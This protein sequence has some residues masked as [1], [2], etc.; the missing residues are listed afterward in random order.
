MSDVDGKGSRLDLREEPDGILCVALHGDMSEETM[1]AMMAALRR[2]AESSREVLVLGDLRRAGTIPAPAR[3]V[4]AEV[5]HT[6][7]LDVA[8]AVGASFS[9]RVVVTLTTKG[10]QLLTGRSYPLAYF[11]SE[12]EA[13]AWLLAQRDALRAKGRPVA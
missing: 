2:V 12:S 4:A 13:R 8:A 10:V 5:M 3:K 6:A 11:D 1:R 9:V 7:R